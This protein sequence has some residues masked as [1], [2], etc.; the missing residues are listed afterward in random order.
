MAAVRPTKLTPVLCRPGREPLWPPP[1]KLPPNVSMHK[2]TVDEA[3]EGHD[4]TSKR[5]LPLTFRSAP[6]NLGSTKT[7]HNPPINI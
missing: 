5:S 2:V 6:L 1:G 3:Q 7:G 4:L